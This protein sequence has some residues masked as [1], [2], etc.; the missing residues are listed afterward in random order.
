M[1][2]H[3]HGDYLAVK[4]DRYTKTRKTTYT[5]FELFSV[6]ARDIPMEVD[7]AA[8]LW[9]HQLLFQQHTASRTGLPNLIPKVL[10]YYS[11]HTLLQATTHRL[12]CYVRMQHALVKQ[13]KAQGRSKA[14]CV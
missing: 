1:F 13:G 11:E 2:W 9:L 12:C 6:K 7:T 8:S 5:S 3:P 10:S 14:I 4:V